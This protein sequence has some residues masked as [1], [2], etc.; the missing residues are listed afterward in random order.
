MWQWQA[1]CRTMEA[2]QELQ[3]PGA[4]GRWLQGASGHQGPLGEHLVTVPG[5]GNA[6]HLITQHHLQ[7]L[8]GKHPFRLS[9]AW[10]LGSTRAGPHGTMLLPL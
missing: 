10:G 4:Q 6:A 2:K 1:L 7:R 9:L 8:L 3:H 5:E